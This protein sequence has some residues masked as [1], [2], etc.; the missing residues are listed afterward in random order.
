MWL[1]FKTVIDTLSLSPD[2]RAIVLS[3]VGDK[4]FTAGLDVQAASQNGVLAQEGQKSKDVARIAVGIKRHVQ[5][6]QDCISSIEKCEKRMDS[7]L[8]SSRN[9]MFMEFERI[10]LIAVCI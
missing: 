10:V 8:F 9:E 3:G 7:L 5:E 4:A 2:I 1:E 6:F